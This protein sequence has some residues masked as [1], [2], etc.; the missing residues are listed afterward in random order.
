M[1]PNTRPPRQPPRAAW[2]VERLV[3]ER[4]IALGHALAP[5]THGAYSSALNS[6]LNF[7][8]LHN[9]PVSPTADTLSFFAVWTSHHISPRS[10]NNYLTGIA[11]EL[12][13]HFADVRA[14][15]N[16]PLVRR[17]VAGCIRL[18]AQ[19]V[20]RKDA[21]TLD[22]LT[23]VHDTL[24]ESSSYDDR[25]FL[26]QLLVGFFALMRLGELVQPDDTRLQNSTRFTHRHTVAC[27]NDRLSF[28]IPCS[29]TDRFFEGGTV[30]VR[31]RPHTVDPVSTFQTYLRSRDAAFGLRHELWIRASGEVPTRG[32]FMRNMRRFFPSRISG[33]SM[34]AGGATALA[35]AGTAPS[36]IQAMGRWS[37]DT[38]QSYIRKHPV[39]LHGLLFDRTSVLH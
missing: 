36:L 37:S 27:D 21:L 35:E 32:W 25:L 26:T 16:S 7:C 39:L 29:K 22:D 12:E 11:N 8:K 31:K 4:S 17:T 3:H 30:M 5:A 13:P 18:R 20:R 19:P 9:M 33:H 10:V 23:R 24:G 2:T 34:R 6:Y 14:C 15:R 28:T 38:W 1:I